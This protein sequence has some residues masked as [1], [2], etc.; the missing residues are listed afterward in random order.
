MIDGVASR[1]F[2]AETLPP[3][4]EPLVHFHDA[5]MENS[6]LRYGTPRAKVEET[7]AKEW[8]SVDAAVTE[9]VVRKGERSLSELL[10]KDLVER[11][12]PVEPRRPQRPRK[13]VDVEDLR[14]AIMES[15]REKKEEQGGP[16]ATARE[17]KKEPASPP[18]ATEE[19]A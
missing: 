3:P 18:L 17:E 1:P 10:G 8:E 11:P 5:I 6:R 16:A 7:L 4:P 2:S 15:L 13:E 9:K 12:R 14:K 19:R